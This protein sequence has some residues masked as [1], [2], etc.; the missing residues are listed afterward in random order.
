MAFLA[1][2]KP[3]SAPIRATAVD[4]EVVVI[5]DGSSI[6]RSFTPEAI[7]ASLEALR[8]A[9]EEALLHREQQQPANA[10]E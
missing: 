8:E 2:C 6:A 5:A 10:A 9:A 3:L 7:L 4:G 1:S